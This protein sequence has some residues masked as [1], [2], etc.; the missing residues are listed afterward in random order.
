MKEWQLIVSGRDNAQNNMSLDE[1]LFASTI[2]DSSSPVLRLYGWSMPSMTIGYFQKYSD[3]CASRVPVVRRLTGGL[4]VEHGSDVSYCF[5]A[6]RDVWPYVDDQEKNYC[7]L[8]SAISTAL[9]SMGVKCEF[10]RGAVNGGRNS[11]CVNTFFPNDLVLE[12]RKILGS[13]QRKRGNT[14]LVQGSIHLPGLM[15]KIEDFARSFSDAFAIEHGIVLVKLPLSRKV[16]Q[17]SEDLSKN[18]YSQDSWNK[19][20]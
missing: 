17:M 2:R 4:S 20:F 12:G 8:H 16:T 13:C 7:A 1:A 9:N 10:Y 6:S 11:V 18:K 15:E 14:L 19:K 5:V 3:F